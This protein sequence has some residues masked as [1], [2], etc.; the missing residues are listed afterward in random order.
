MKKR[1]KKSF[2]QAVVVASSVGGFVF[3][4]SKHEVKTLFYDFASSALSMFVKRV[5]RTYLIRC[6]FICRID[7]RRQVGFFFC[8]GKTDNGFSCFEFQNY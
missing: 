8:K 3:H 5:L 4:Y 6:Y 1:L 2:E 7:G